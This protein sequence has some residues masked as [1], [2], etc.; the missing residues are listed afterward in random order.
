M[1]GGIPVP[2]AGRFPDSQIRARRRLP[3]F[4]QWLSCLD[5]G[6]ALPA[7]SDEIVQASHLFPSYPLP[8]GERLRLLFRI[9]FSSILYY[10]VRG[11]ARPK[12]DFPQ[13][14]PPGLACFADA[15]VNF[16]RM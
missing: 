13:V 6:S 14:F 7:Y 8:E 5:T 2:A 16:R 4:R 15:S 11:N 3:G 9:L 10:G 1:P 12:W